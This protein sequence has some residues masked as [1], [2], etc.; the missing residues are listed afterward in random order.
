MVFLFFLCFLISSLVFMMF[1]DCLMVLFVY[2]MLLLM[3]S[4]VSAS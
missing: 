1:L 2:S 4:S 3:C